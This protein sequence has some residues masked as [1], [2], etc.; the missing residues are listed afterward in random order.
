MQKTILS[1][2]DDFIAAFNS[3]KQAFAKLEGNTIDENE[4]ITAEEAFA[5][6][7]TTIEFIEKK[8]KV[9]ECQRWKHL[10]QQECKDSSK[11]SREK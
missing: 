3:I 9:C 1:D 10:Y 6:A 8:Q 4:E 7:Q 5:L 2:N 11:L